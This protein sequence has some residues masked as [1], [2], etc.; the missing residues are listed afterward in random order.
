MPAIEQAFM[1]AVSD[2]C[3][4]KRGLLILPGRIITYCNTDHCTKVSR[5]I[6]TSTDLTH[7]DGIHEIGLLEQSV[8]LALILR[9][10][11]PTFVGRYLQQQNCPETLNFTS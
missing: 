1:E 2:L 4:K 9:E 11:F 6:K 8:S 5:E 7:L 3:S 10:M